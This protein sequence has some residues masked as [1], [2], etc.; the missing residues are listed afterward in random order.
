[1]G[2]AVGSANTDFWNLET[3]NDAY[4]AGLWCADGYHRTS[5]VGISNTDLIL[6][7]EFKNFFLKLFPRNRIKLRIYESDS[8]KRRTKAFHLYVN[9]R[10]LLRKFKQIKKNANDFIGE[11][12]IIPYIAGRFDGDGSIAKD[13]YSDC[14]IV[15][16]N[17]REAEVD[18]N[19]LRSLD[20]RK[21]KIYNYRA[22]KTFCLYFSR[23]ET[24]KFLSLIYP[25][26]LRLQKSVFAPRRDLIVAE[27]VSTSV[28][29]NF[30]KKNLGGKTPA[31]RKILKLN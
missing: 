23:L 27:M 21:M 14:R 2:N 31:A 25:Y 4:I 29:Q 16:G 30:C 19:L 1:M 6:V 5:S 15:Y 9:S 8:L 17:Y 28:R 20:F 12:L 24:E 26:S 18:L 7:E 10:P 13:F 22:A 3:V 11:E